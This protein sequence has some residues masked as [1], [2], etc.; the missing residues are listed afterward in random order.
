[1]GLGMS[2]LIF[3]DDRFEAFPDPLSNWI[4]WDH[5]EENFAEVG[6]QYLCFLSQARAEAFCCLLNRFFRKPMQHA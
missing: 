4:V 6:T 5:D 2:A 1:M 3:S